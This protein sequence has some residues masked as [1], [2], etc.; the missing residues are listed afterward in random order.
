M[1]GIAIKAYKLFLDVLGIEKEKI[2]I[3]HLHQQ[4]AKIDE[5]VLV[6]LKV[7]TRG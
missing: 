4:L 3:D 2:E 6:K 1:G 7:D 5:D